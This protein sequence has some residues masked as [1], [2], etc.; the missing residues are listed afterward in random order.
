MIGIS[1]VMV[2]KVQN[3]PHRSIIEFLNYMIN[4][5][6]HTIW[7][8]WFLNHFEY[9]F[10]VFSRLL[11]CLDWVKL[12]DVLF[13]VLEVFPRCS[14]LIFSSLSF[15]SCS[16]KAIVLELALSNFVGSPEGLCCYQ[17]LFNCFT[18]LSLGRIITKFIH[19]SKEFWILRSFN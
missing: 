17:H 4:P 16:L 13:F 15:L 9:L 12:S 19:I 2:L 6:F 10:F 18:Y 11:D 5:K 7:F 1:C 3:S 14:Q 8:Y